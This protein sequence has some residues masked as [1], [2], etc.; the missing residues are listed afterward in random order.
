[1]NFHAAEANLVMDG[2]AEAEV[3]IDGEFYKKITI[4]GPRLYNIYTSTDETYTEH[5]VQINFTGQEIE[6]FAWTFG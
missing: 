6:A 2:N 3:I 1:M 4:D 5:E